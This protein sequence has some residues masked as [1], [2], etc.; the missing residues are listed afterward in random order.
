MKTPVY[1][2]NPDCSRYESLKIREY[3]EKIRIPGAYI[4]TVISAFFPL[5][6]SMVRKKYCIE[7][8]RVLW[9]SLRG[10]TVAFF[11]VPFFFLYICCSAGYHH[12]GNGLHAKIQKNAG[13]LLQRKPELSDAH[14]IVEERSQEGPESEKMLCLWLWRI[15]FAMISNTK[16]WYDEGGDKSLSP[17]TTPELSD[18]DV[19]PVRGLSYRGGAIVAR[20]ET[21]Y[22]CASLLSISPEPWLFLVLWLP[23]CSGIIVENFFGI[24]VHL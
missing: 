11:L 20:G 7:A 4:E 5:I 13:K 14:L 18:N 22:E 21:S 24:R 9:F 3:S 2:G 12:E 15:P 10:K 17:R 1:N 16:H 19:V 23:G 8:N 6:V